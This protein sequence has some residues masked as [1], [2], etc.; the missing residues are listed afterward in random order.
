MIHSLTV[1]TRFEDP[2][3]VATDLEEGDVTARVQRL[4]VTAVDTSEPTPSEEPFVITYSVADTAGNEAQV[5]RRRIYVHDPCPGG[6]LCSSGQCSEAGSNLCTAVDFG[7][8]EAEAEVEGPHVALVGASQVTVALGAAYVACSAESPR[9]DVCDPG[10]DASDALE[11]D[12]RTLLL[13]C[14]PDGERN[15][16]EERGIGGCPFDSQVPAVYSLLFEVFNSGGAS[17]SAVRNVT[18]QASCPPGESLCLSGLTCSSQGVCVD[19]LAASLESASEPAAP[20]NTAPTLVLQTDDVAGMYI[21]L[22]QYAEYNR[23]GDGVDP[24]TVVP[25]E[26]GAIATDAEDGDLTSR[27]L[28]CP[29]ASCLDKGCDGHEFETKGVQGCLDTGAEVGTVFEIEFVVMDRGSPALSASATRVVTIVA[30]CP[31]GEELCLE[32]RACSAVPCDVRSGLLEEGP[33]RRLMS[34]DEVTDAAAIPVS[35]AEAIEAEIHRLTSA[36]EGTAAALQALEDAV[37]GADGAGENAIWT[38]YHGG[39]W[40]RGAEIEQT[41]HIEALSASLNEL[42]GGWDQMIEHSAT[43]AVQADEAIEQSLAD[44]NSRLD[45]ILAGVSEAPSGRATSGGGSAASDSRSVPENEE[46]VP[47]AAGQTRGTAHSPD[48]P[49]STYSRCDQGGPGVVETTVDIHFDVGADSG[50]S[51]IDA[52]GNAGTPPISPATPSAS[53]DVVATNA[54]SAESSTPDDFTIGEHEASLEEGH[55]GITDDDSGWHG[56]REG[57]TSSHSVHQAS[58]RVR[59]HVALNNLLIGGMLLQSEAS[60]ADDDVDDCAAAASSERFGELFGN[61]A[62]QEQSMTTPR[63]ADPVFTVGAELY[64]PAVAAKGTA[65]YYNTTPSSEEFEHRTGTAHPFKTRPE[66]GLAMDAYPFFFDVRAP[67]ARTEELLLYLDEGRYTRGGGFRSLRAELLSYNSQTHLLALSQVAFRAHPSGSIIV[68][69]TTLPLSFGH[70]Q[71]GTG[72]ASI[73]HYTNH[74]PW[75]V[76]ATWAAVVLSVFVYHIVGLSHSLWATTR[77]D[78]QRK[79]PLSYMVQSSISFVGAAV[80]VAVI[81]W[82]VAQ[83][84]YMDDQGLLGHAAIDPL[85]TTYDVYDDLFAEA[86]FLLPSKATL[87]DVAW[88]PPDEAQRWRLPDDETGLGG[89]VKVLG[90]AN[91]L[92]ALDMILRIVEAVNCMFIILRLLFAVCFHRKLAFVLDTLSAS[93]V[94]L[95]HMFALMTALLGQYALLTHV[96]YGPYYETFSTGQLASTGV[97][98]L[99]MLGDLMNFKVLDKSKYWQQPRS[100]S[101]VTQFVQDAFVIGSLSA[102]FQFCLL[103]LLMGVITGAKLKVRQRE[104]Q[105][106]SY[107]NLWDDILSNVKAQ[108]KK[109]DMGWPTLDSTI[110]LLRK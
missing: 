22:T 65:G 87:A 18:V 11:G 69:A 27:V 99:A 61:S 43:S 107:T 7:E 12:L 101:G 108:S 80:H 58:L 66:A 2:G 92:A 16:F 60:M 64:D 93:A 24:T 41:Q 89:F 38:R 88:R 94:S 68:S 50:N 17:A 28:A 3:V 47:H 103:H 71:S 40:L 29:P 96:L 15:R 59:P 75:W 55:F 4:G 90:Q 13:A 85:D 49:L 79:L 5:T 37:A 74:L 21:S 86:N 26:A 25:C 82:H 45:A 77:Q 10:A 62:C 91:Q 1:G 63:G 84:A 57:G 110:S 46:G 35:D 105:I 95:A 6:R 100:N 51:D 54:H 67:R 19:D 36:M 42:G 109:H 14:S 31:T 44:M 9:S 81:L 33:G 52:I 78:E 53:E 102:L 20:K 56:F 39:I 73:L 32:D 76:C 70:T 98:Q 48:I 72:F 104:S 30:A 106:H 83:R 34:A 8:A 23:C 97:L